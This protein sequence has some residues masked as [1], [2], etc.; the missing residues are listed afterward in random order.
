[1]NLAIGQFIHADIYVENDYDRILDSNYS[2]QIESLDWTG[3]FQKWLLHLSSITDTPRECELSLRLTGDRQMQQYNLQYRHLDK[4]T[5]V[6]AFA[7]METDI[8]LPADLDEPIYLG[9]IIISLDTAIYQAIEQKHALTV[10]LAWL[11]SHG[12]LHLLGWDHPDDKSLQQMLNQQSEL[13][14]SLN[15]SDPR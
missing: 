4:S 6:L 10:E 9:D 13:I 11:S 1:M 14:Q 3:W 15:A 8:N 12:L 2:E 7:A 5:D